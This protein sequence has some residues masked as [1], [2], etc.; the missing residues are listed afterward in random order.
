MHRP[1]PRDL[2]PKANRERLRNALW[3]AW[4]RIADLKAQQAIQAAKEPPMQ[5]EQDPE[6]EMAYQS[7]NSLWDKALSNEAQQATE[8]ACE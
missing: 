1:D 3:D 2:G 8:T 6:L 7:W 5:Q 4:D